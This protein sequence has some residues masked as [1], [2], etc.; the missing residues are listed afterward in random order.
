MICKLG[1]F[2][3]FV[4]VPF[5]FVVVVGAGRS[6]AYLKEDFFNDISLLYCVLAAVSIGFGKFSGRTE[7]RGTGRSSRELALW[8]CGPL[9]RHHG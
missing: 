2:F 9:N 7:R 6:S 8:L 4:S 3:V 1:A 5:D